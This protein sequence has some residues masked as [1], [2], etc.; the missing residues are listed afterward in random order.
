MNVSFINQ[1]LQIYVEIYLGELSIINIALY[2]DLSLQL[3]VVV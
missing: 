2:A 3:H 1:I